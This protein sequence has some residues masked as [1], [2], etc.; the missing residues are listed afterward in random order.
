MA[1]DGSDI[2]VYATGFRN[3]FDIDFNSEGDMFTA[4][5]SANIKIDEN[6]PDELHYVRPGGDHGFPDVLGDPPA[7][8]TTEKPLTTWFPPLAPGGLEFYDGGTLTALTENDLLL[9]KWNFL[10]IARVRINRVDG[11]YVFVEDEN[12]VVGFGTPVTDVTVAPNGDIY[13][14]DW[15]G[16]R[17]FRISPE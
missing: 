2:Q 4:D 7:G 13:I 16:G 17:I 10:E 6:P 9:A 12:I 1:E 5:N 15:G 8:S 11:E 14:A 3:P